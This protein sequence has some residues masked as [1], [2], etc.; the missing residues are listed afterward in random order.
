MM[1]ID[2]YVLRIIS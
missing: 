1:I 2:H